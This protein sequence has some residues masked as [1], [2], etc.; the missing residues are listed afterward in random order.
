MFPSRVLALCC[1]LF[2]G[3]SLSAQTTGKRVKQRA[4]DRSEQRT[5]Q[6]IDQ[7]VD[8][9]VDKAFE[10][11]GGLFRKKPA[12]TEEVQDGGLRPNDGQD[13]YATEAEATQAVMNALGLGGGDWEPYTHPVTFSLTMHLTERKKN[14]KVTTTELQIGTTEDCFAVLTYGTTAP[15]RHRMLLNT[16]TG[17][18][19]MIATDKHGETQAYRLRLP[20]LRQ[21][22]QESA[23]ETLEHITFTRTGQHR[24]IQG[25]D[26]ELMLVEDRKAGTTTESWVTQELDL[27]AADVFGSLTG[28]AGAGKQTAG[29]QQ[30][31][32]PYP[33]FPIESTTTDGRT[34]TTVT[35][36]NIRV[37]V[38]AVDRS[39]FT[40]EGIAVQEVGF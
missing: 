14:G 34:T 20:N 38:D 35:M 13:A 36:Q 15:E 39:L 12:A 24:S 31:P 32:A 5:N 40:T 4:R 2:L 23:T 33:G 19:T 30:L 18:T 27:N 16:Q 17:K 21:A 26:C 6:R 1:L 25:Y 9:G 28:L 37:G 11:I 3:V 10:A 8:E 7:K 22:I 29:T